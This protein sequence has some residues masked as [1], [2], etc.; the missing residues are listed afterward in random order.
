MHEKRTGTAL[1]ILAAALYALNAPFSKHLLAHAGP[2]MMAALLYLGAGLGLILYSLGEKA[3]G[4]ASPARFTPSPLFWGLSS[5]W[6]WASAP[7]C[8]SIWVCW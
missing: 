8:S 7:G 6:C 5:V 1:A 3:L 2:T 4:K